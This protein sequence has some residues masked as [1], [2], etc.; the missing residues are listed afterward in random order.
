LPRLRQRP[1]AHIGRERKA[2][3][4]RRWRSL[5]IR[6]PVS[7]CITAVAVAGLM[8]IGGCKRVPGHQGFVSDAALIEGIKPGVDNRDSVIKTLGRPSFEGQFDTHDWYYV[9]RDTRTYAYRLPVPSAQLITHIRFDAAG[10]VASVE[11]A[12]MEKIA[13]IRP[14]R[15]KTPTL[16]RDRTIFE[17]LFGNIGQ[18]GAVGK[19]GPSTDNPNGG[20]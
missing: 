15:D 8:F 9:A 7:R 10:N 3:M 6:L 14:V 13:A 1:L 2:V 17:D 4:I 11:K 16:G 19:G 12:G 20:Q 18:V 5:M